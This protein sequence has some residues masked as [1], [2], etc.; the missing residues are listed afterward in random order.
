[1]PR[2][3]AQDTLQRREIECGYTQGRTSLLRAE[4]LSSSRMASRSLCC[5]A[6]FQMPSL[7]A[8]ARGSGGAAPSAQQRSAAQRS[9]GGHA[10]KA[11][12]LAQCVRHAQ[13][14][15]AAVAHAA[16]QQLQRHAVQRLRA[17]KLQHL[18][19]AAILPQPPRA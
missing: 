2:P 1:M 13:E 3:H 11:Q 10:L 18:V 4:P 6:Y 5:I 12:S 8:A 9:A 14:E 16:G 7:P 15:L 19:V 17:Q